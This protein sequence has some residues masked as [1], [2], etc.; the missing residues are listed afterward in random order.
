MNND[1]DDKDL[2][3]ELE[4]LL[5]E[6]GMKT[7]GY[8]MGYFLHK[9]FST[10]ILLT[11]LVNLFSFGIVMGFSKEFLKIADIYSIQ[12]FIIVV[13]MY[14]LFETTLKILAISLFFKVVIKTFGLLFLFINISLFWVINLMVHD[15]TFLTHPFNIFTFT[16]LFMMIRTL[17]T[18]YVRKTKWIQGGK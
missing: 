18:V 10:H 13:I 17:F 4:K 14:S 9:N 1:N 11:I 8:K 2:Q 7:N 6:E 12:A 15:F 3:E 16:I 5:K